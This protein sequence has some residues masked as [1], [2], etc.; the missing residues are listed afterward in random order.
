[1][2]PKVA[3]TM[4]RELR[5]VPKERDLNRFFRVALSL[6]LTENI[7]TIERNIPTAAISMGAIT[8]LYCITTSPE[9][10][11]AAAPSAAVARIEPQYDS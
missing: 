9:L 10:D 4:R 3:P 5:L 11:N 2:M 8:A 7:P 1:M 6:V